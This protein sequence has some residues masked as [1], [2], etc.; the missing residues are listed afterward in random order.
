MMII[1]VIIFLILITFKQKALLVETNSARLKHENFVMEIKKENIK[2][3][4]KTLYKSFN[5]ALLTKRAQSK[6][7]Y[8]LMIN[9]EKVSSSGKIFSKTPS[10]TMQ[11]F[12]NFDKDDLEILPKT[13]IESGS[14]LNENSKSTVIKIS[15]NKF[16]AK[17][18]LINS[19][20][21]NSFLYEFSNVKNGEIITIEIEPK[22]AKKI[23]LSVNTI[24]IFYN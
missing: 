8:I 18:K 22:I 14:I 15:S 16:V 5:A 9:G 11:L 12:E 2:A 10:I 23:G 17:T 19:Q 4:E 7:T 13:I 20:K 24:E 6:F 3:F 21:G 1:S